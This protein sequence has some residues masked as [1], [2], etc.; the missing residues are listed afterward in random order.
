MLRRIFC[1]LLFGAPV[2]P[3]PAAPTIPADQPV[4]RAELFAIL[5]DAGFT[6][7]DMEVANELPL[8]FVNLFSHSPAFQ[9]LQEQVSEL[10]AWRS[11]NGRIDVAKFSRQLLEVDGRLEG[12]AGK[13]LF[14]EPLEV[15]DPAS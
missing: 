14:K 10:E 1:S 11:G 12:S 3:T 15:V 9:K 6:N 13:Y 4:T 2:I 5:K 8:P 7:A